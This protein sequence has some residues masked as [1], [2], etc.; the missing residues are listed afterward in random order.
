MECARL[1]GAFGGPWAHDSGSK[2]YALQ[3]LRAVQPW[4]ARPVDSCP[5]FNGF[6]KH[7]MT[8]ASVSP[9]PAQNPKL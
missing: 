4:L 9:T 6:R 7:D 3:T 8:S 5:T 2:L 1:A